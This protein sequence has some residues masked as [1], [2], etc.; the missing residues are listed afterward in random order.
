MLLGFKRIFA[1]YVESG[2]KTH[3]IRGPRKTRPRVGDVA[4]CYVD[5]RQKTMRLLGRWPVVKVEEIRIQEAGP[6]RLF[7]AIDGVGLDPHEAE[8]LFHRD[9]FRDKGGETYQSMAQ[10]RM[11]WADKLPFVGDLIHWDFERPVSNSLTKSRVS[12]SRNISK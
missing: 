12:A 3:T 8:L 9:G 11:F 2:S 10:A 1:P 4:H 5:P 7:V 6:G